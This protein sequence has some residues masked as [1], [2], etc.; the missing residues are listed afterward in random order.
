[1][2]VG[3]R[4]RARVHGQHR[5]AGGPGAHGRR[6]LGLGRGRERRHGGRAG[7]PE[8]FGRG[9]N[10]GAPR[11]RGRDEQLVHRSRFDGAVAPHQRRVLA[12]GHRRAGRGARRGDAVSIPRRSPGSTAS[13]TTSRSCRSRRR[14]PIATRRRPRP[15]RRRP[16]PTPRAQGARA[17]DCDL[18]DERRL[19]QT[20]IADARAPP[21]PPPAQRRRGDRLRDA[22]DDDRRSRRIRCRGPRRSLEAMLAVAA[23]SSI[24]SSSACRIRSAPASS[25]SDGLRDRDAPVVPAARHDARRRAPRSGAGGHA[26]H[27]RRRER[28]RGEDARRPA[29]AQRRQ[30]LLRTVA[31]DHRGLGPHG[32]QRPHAAHG[33]QALRRRSR[34]GDEPLRRRRLLG[35]GPRRPRPPHGASTPS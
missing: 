23:T 1:M 13:T 28:R 25:G 3:V 35:R 30:A 12:D 10:D 24:R 19:P 20:F 31:A 29:R 33:R 17:R 15:S 16:S 22:R 21:L 2:R 11:P 9:G 14:T 4:Q 26:R 6:G 32:R 7:D 27:V 18:G 5:R 34:R 8:P